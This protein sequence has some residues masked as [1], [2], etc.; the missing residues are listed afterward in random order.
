MSPPAL[1]P[2]QEFPL[3]W[4]LRKA[5]LVAQGGGGWFR[6][7]EEKDIPHPSTLPLSPSLHLARQ[8]T[9]TANSPAPNPLSKK[10]DLLLG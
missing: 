10:R 8:P 2:I 4:S 3:E 5:V 9:G 6:W 1:T 7:V